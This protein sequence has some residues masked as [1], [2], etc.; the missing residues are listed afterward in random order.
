MSLWTLVTILTCLWAAHNGTT[1]VDINLFLF[2]VM[3]WLEL[4]CNTSYRD[5]AVIG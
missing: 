5:L 1:M 3:I 2:V 4:K